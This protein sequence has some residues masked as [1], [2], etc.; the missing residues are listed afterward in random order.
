MERFDATPV[1]EKLR[2]RGRFFKDGVKEMLEP[3]LYRIYERGVKNGTLSRKDA[4][5]ISLRLG[6]MPHDIWGFEKWE[7]P[8]EVEPPP[9]AS[10]KNAFKTHCK[11]GHALVEGNLLYDK[12]GG[13]RCRT[14][15]NETERQYQLRKRAARVAALA[16]AASEPELEV[17]S[18]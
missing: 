12:K 18:V 1:I 2:L 9:S 4:D 6:L 3:D 16:V 5:H 7:G 10:L 17:V 14:C 15:K 13:R 11:Y 8:D